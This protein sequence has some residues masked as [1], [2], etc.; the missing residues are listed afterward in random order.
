MIDPSYYGLIEL[1]IFAVVV[2]GFGFWQLW[3]V[4]RASKALNDSERK[5]S[6]RRDAE[7]RDG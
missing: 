3:D 2:L 7:R 1:V 4:N 5:D 6:E